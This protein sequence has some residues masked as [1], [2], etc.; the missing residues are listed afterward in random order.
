ML[1]Q[2]FHLVS[3]ESLVF[4]NWPI[5]V[6]FFPV[7]LLSAMVRSFG[8]YTFN[9]GSNQPIICSRTG[10]SALRCGEKSVESLSDAQWLKKIPIAP[11]GNIFP[12]AAPQSQ[13]PNQQ[14]IIS[15]NSKFD[16]ALQGSFTTWLC[17][18]GLWVMEVN[19]QRSFFMPHRPLEDY[20]CSRF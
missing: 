6:G 16:W 3:T 8:S 5:W 11:V 18:W 9:H 2:T 4:G 1:G 20:S 7:R 17:S 10:L 19:W 14:D 13:H 12:S 15:R